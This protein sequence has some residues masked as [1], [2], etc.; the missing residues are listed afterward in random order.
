MSFVFTEDKINKS[1]SS[2]DIAK[3]T[4]C[5]SVS[6]PMYTTFNSFFVS[7]IFNEKFGVTFRM[8]KESPIL[9]SSHLMSLL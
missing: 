2:F 7:C 8:K 3:R 6:V 4:F 1:K 9:F 5:W